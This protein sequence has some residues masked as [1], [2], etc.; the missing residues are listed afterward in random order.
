MGVAGSGKTTVGQQAARRLSWRFIEGDAYHPR[1]NV[2]KMRAGHPLD[3]ADRRPW[4]AALA[5]EIA[6]SRAGGHSLVIACSALRRAYRDALTHRRRDDVLLVHLVGEPAVIAAR[7]TTRRHFMPLGLLESQF[8]TL[9]S[10][11][12]EERTLALDVRLAAAVLASRVVV[13]AAGRM[14]GTPGRS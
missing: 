14:G 6:A 5:R 12:A 3:D 9:E 13:D 11:G 8:A 4:L 1:A 2:T 10:P 7:M